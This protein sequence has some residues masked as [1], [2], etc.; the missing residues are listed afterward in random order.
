MLTL[1]CFREKIDQVDLASVS[2]WYLSIIA[3]ILSYLSI[4]GCICITLFKKLSFQKHPET[5]AEV[6]FLNNVVFSSGHK[7]WKL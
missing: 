1:P 7:W 3:H 2:L 4:D 6:E 5:K